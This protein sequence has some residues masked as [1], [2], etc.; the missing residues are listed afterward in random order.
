MRL[1]FL[2]KLFSYKIS[3]FTF[4]KDFLKSPFPDFWGDE[5]GLKLCDHVI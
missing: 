5:R 3:A 4:F 1:A 2:I